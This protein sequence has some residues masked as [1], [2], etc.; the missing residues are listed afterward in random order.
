MD[1]GLK[2]RQALV[3]ASSQGLGWACA[4]ALA[5]EGCTVYLNG[6]DAPKLTAAAARLREITGASEPAAS[7]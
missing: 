5:E 1:L 7:A 3:C 2:G 4:T 6:R